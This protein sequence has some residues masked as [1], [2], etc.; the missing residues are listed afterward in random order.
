MTTELKDRLRKFAR[1]KGRLTVLT[2]AG[3][4]A[5]SGIP[6]FRGPE[7]YWNV[8]SVNYTPQEIGT[9]EM[10]Q[11]NPE[12]VWKWYLFRR[13]VC[14]QSQ[15]NPGHQAIVEL[16]KILGDR[17]TLI[18]QNV[19]GLHLRAGNSL[20][21]TYL[22]HGTLDYV[23]CSVSCTDQLYPFPKGIGDKDRDSD[24]T[25]EEMKLLACP[26]CG[27]LTRPHIL[28]F[29]EYYDERY[30]RFKSSLQVAKETELLITI[31][32]SGATTLPVQ[33]VDLALKSGATM[34][35]INIEPNIFSHAAVE[36]GSGYFLQGPSG[37]IL[38]QL[39]EYF[40]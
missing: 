19:D 35:D 40:R 9:F 4:S 18:T 32:T 1:G 26:N 6:T 27:A 13:T 20:E 8:G 15:P 2:G 30:F 38:P 31:G 24:L 22:I 21:R 16:E 29:D 37:E 39:L 5:E 25:A 12:E 33:V 10:F 7:G 28:W 14:H 34:I 11:K 36:M 23:R 17:F 3:V